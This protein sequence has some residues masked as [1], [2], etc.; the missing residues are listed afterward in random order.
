MFE[1]HKLLYSFLITLQIELDK[2]TINY[3]QINFFLKGNLSLDKSSTIKTK[4]MLDWL[5]DDA[6]HHCLFLSKNFP[7]KFGNL[8]NHILEWKQWITHDQPEK[9]SLPNPFN[10]FERLMLL[11]CFCQS[12]IV[13]A[14]NNYITKMMGE[15]YIIP[16]TLHFDSVFEQSTAQIPVIFILSPGSDPTNDIQK[17]AERKTY[18]AINDEQKSLQIL[19]MGQNQEKLALQALHT[20]QQQG[21]WLLLQNC[22]LLLP[23]LNQLEKEL[24]ASTKAHVIV[25]ISSSS[26]YFF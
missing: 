12:R 1:K 23:F 21:T 25:E 14:I 24:E 3:Q 22:H 7:E 10:D 4:P 2:Q 26:L 6:W 15:K 5:T 8:L 20:A 9:I 11:R 16:P 19:A 18:A 17:L 13:F